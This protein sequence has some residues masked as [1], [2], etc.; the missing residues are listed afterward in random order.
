M[1]GWKPMKT[2]HIGSWCGHLEEFVAWPETDGSW[3]LVP[4]WGEAT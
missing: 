4:V 2:M 1:N 3:R